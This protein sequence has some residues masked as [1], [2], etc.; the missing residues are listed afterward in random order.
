MG[1]KTAVS[2]THKPSTDATCRRN[3]NLQVY[4]DVPR[5]CSWK[6][7]YLQP[8]ANGELILFTCDV[9]L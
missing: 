7:G 6:A 2:K 1:P 3:Q 9:F 5:V 8:K 4:R